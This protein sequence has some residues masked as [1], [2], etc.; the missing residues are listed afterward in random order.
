MQQVAREPVLGLHVV[1][2]VLAMQRNPS[3][4]KLFSWGCRAFAALALRPPQRLDYGHELGREPPRPPLD[5][6][7]G[8]SSDNNYCAGGLSSYVASLGARKQQQ[9]HSESA[10]GA[11]RTHEPSKSCL[12]SMHS[13]LNRLE[14]KH[15]AA[16]LIAS[17]LGQVL[18][19][20]GEQ[21]RQRDSM[22][23]KRSRAQKAVLEA[24]SI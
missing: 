23:Q 20:H 17:D 10:C 2:E 5:A 8:T 12:G 11:L 13:K 16:K 6:H 14:I 4:A 15:L 21:H 24:P 3:S 9:Q 7:S 22:E 1:V 18:Y 19:A